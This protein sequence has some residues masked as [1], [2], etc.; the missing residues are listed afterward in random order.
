M[1]SKEGK[2]TTIEKELSK[3]PEPSRYKPN[4]YA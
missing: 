2:D 1:A 4:I 3:V